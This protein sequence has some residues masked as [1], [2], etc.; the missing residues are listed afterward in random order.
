LYHSGVRLLL[1]TM[2]F[3]VGTACSGTGDGLIT[4]VVRCST[5]SG[6]PLSAINCPISKPSKTYTATLSGCPG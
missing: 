6:A 3:K 5:M 1:V 2:L 4:G